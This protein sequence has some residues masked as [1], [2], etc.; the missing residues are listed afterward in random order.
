MIRLNSGFIKIRRASPRS[1]ECTIQLLFQFPYELLIDSKFNNGIR[2]YTFCL[3]VDFLFWSVFN[4]FC[5]II[6]QSCFISEKT[7]MDL[8]VR[9]EPFSTCKH[10]NVVTFNNL[11]TSK[12][13]LFQS[14]FRLFIY[15]LYTCFVVIVI[16]L[17]TLYFFCI[18]CVWPVPLNT[19]IRKL[20]TKNLTYLL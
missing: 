13:Y 3:F 17:V 12:C 1:V 15:D 18:W 11:V 8:S 4:L 6:R 9:I 7:W 19:S 10:A 2:F 14:I 5:L 20:E 16:I